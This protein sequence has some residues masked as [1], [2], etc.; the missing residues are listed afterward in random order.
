MP[1]KRNMVNPEGEAQP[2]FRDQDFVFEDSKKRMIGSDG[3]IIELDD[4]KQKAEPPK[5]FKSTIS[6]TETRE[7]KWMMDMLTWDY[8]VY[9]FTVSFGSSKWE[10]GKRY[11]DFDKLDNRV[12]WS[13]SFTLFA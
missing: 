10:V 13:P 11:S 2:Q 1:P 6:G 12:R 3:Q 8:T 9:Q 7:Q 4:P 5:T